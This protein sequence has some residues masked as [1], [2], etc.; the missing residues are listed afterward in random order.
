MR[1]PPSRK[2]SYRPAGPVAL[3]LFAVCLAAAPSTAKPIPSGSSK[4]AA[5]LQAACSA[6]HRRSRAT[7]RRAGRASYRSRRSTAQSLESRACILYCRFVTPAA[8]GGGREASA[9]DDR[10]PPKE[11]P[12]KKSMSHHLG[13]RFTRGKSDLPLFPSHSGVGERGED[14]PS[15]FPPRGGE[16]TAPQRCSL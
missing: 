15:S 7:T 3:F 9:R 10:R 13:G 6:P 8:G 16:S 14:T 1:R 5:S 4:A 2:E 12:S 11:E